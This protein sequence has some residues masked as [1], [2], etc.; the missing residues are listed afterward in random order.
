MGTAAAEE[1]KCGNAECGRPIKEKAIVAEGKIFHS[2]CFKCADCRAPLGTEYN[3]M[4]GKVLCKNCLDKLKNVPC[5][6]C[7]KP[8]EKQCYEIIG[9]RITFKNSKKHSTISRT[10]ESVANVVAFGSLFRPVSSTSVENRS[11]FLRSR[12][13]LKQK[14]P[15]SKN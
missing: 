4:N 15:K 11:T 6:G 2:S 14:A 13:F 1:P 9:K 7:G 8:I 3:V 12:K 10:N 5:A